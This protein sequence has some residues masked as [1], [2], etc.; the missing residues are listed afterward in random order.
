MLDII[1]TFRSWTIMVGS[2]LT[3]SQHN[4]KTKGL[5]YFEVPKSLIKY[6]RPLSTNFSAI[7]YLYYDL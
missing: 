7:F 3:N 5:C 1:L 6:Y 4:Y 2:E